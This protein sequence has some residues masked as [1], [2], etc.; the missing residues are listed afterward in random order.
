MYRALKIPLLQH[1]AQIDAKTWLS[2][3]PPFSDTL[4][5]ELQRAKRF[6]RPLSLIMSD[7]DLLRNVNN[8]Y[9]H[10]AGDAVLTGIGKLIRATIR[11]Y[12]FAGR[13][14][15]EEFVDCLARDWHR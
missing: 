10:L 3:R 4:T 14:G 1:E 11:E 8:T 12:D 7:L 6:T 2:Q 13:F 5:A 9:G 15:G